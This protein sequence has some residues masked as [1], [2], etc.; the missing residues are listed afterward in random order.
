MKLFVIIAVLTFNVNPIFKNLFTAPTEVDILERALD[1]STQEVAVCYFDMETNS[2]CKKCLQPYCA[3]PSHLKSSIYRCQSC[4]RKLAKNYRLKRKINGNPV[5]STKMPL[6][7]HKK[8]LEDYQAI[9]GTTYY[10]KRYKKHSSDL[11]FKFKNKVRASTK[12]AVKRGVIKKEPCRV[13]GNQKSEIHHIDYSKP[14]EI[15]WLCREHHMEWHKILND[16]KYKIFN[17]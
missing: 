6:E 12:G 1:V 4:S 7:Y 9:H 11:Y 2:I 13:C 15:M 8:Y 14:L 17:T 10:K 5:I 16:F 3:P